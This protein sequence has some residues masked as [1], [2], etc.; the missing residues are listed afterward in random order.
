[1]LGAKGEAL[2][3]VEPTMAD[4]Q[5]AADFPQPPLP[6]T[7]CDDTAERLGVLLGALP[8]KYD[9]LP[10]VV[11]AW[12]DLPDAIRRAILAIVEAARTPE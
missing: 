10:A 7:T 8:T 3:G 6:Q 4:L 1:K 9:G 2:V 12:P 5:S 11:K